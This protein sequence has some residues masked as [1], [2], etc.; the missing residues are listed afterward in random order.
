MKVK[1][2]FSGSRDQLL[3]RLFSM[4]SS[5]K[6]TV[7]GKDIPWPDAARVKVEYDD[8]LGNN[9]VKVFIEWNN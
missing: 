9:A 3:Q 5:K 4:V 6:L 8:G 7:G 1:E 2:E